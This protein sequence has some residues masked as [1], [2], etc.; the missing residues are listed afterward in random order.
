MFRLTL[1]FIGI[2]GAIDCRLIGPVDKEVDNPHR[3]FRRQTSNTT[4]R[5]THYGFGNPADS[6]Y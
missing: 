2:I 6:E 5:T 4:T 1:F 3:I